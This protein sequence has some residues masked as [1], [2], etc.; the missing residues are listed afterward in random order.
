MGISL[1]QVSRQ[2][3]GSIDLGSRKL[4]DLRPLVDL[5]PDQCVELRG[6]GARSTRDR[7]STRLNSSHL[8]ISYA[9]FCLKKKKTELRVD[10]IRDDHETENVQV[11]VRG[12]RGNQR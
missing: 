3:R 7:K 5:A 10:K 4:H 12:I 1:V 6:R 8:G 9:V 2:A 11:Q